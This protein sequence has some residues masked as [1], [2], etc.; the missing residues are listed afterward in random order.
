MFAF[1]LITFFGLV[2]SPRELGLP[3]ADEL[4][5]PDETTDQP[6]SSGKIKF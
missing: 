3:L 2:P 4:E 6:N 1:G 5:N